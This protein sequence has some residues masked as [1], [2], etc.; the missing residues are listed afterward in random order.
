MIRLQQGGRRK[1]D[2]GAKMWR[3]SRGAPR[4]SG[5]TAG[6]GRKSEF[7][8]VVGGWDKGLADYLAGRADPLEPLRLFWPE[9]P[10]SGKGQVRQEEPGPRGD[11]VSGR[12]SLATRL[13]PLCA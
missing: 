1:A 13:P 7:C 10:D 5:D 9:E 3:S 2:R 11:G 12:E 8:W 4:C 6:R